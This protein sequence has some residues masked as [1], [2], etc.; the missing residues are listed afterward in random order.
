MEEICE[1]CG[2]VV[3]ILI[4]IDD[5]EVCDGCALYF[6]ENETWGEVDD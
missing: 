3:E 6:E 1:H 2:Q 5:M 4:D